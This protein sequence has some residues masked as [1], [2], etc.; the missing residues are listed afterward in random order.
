MITSE[1]RVERYDWT[2]YS[3]QC[4]RGSG[5][6][7]D[8]GSYQLLVKRWKCWGITIWKRVLDREDIPMH[9]LVELGSIGT[10][11]WTSKF[12]PYTEKQR[13]NQ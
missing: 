1:I 8:Q 7:E 6:C 2:R 4:P 3:K 10:C 12:Q 5:Y 13:S 11:S 9:V